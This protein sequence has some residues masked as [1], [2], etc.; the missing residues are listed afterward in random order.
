M[1]EGSGQGSGPPPPPAP[2]PPPPQP[3]DINQLAPRDLGGILGAAFDIY[4]MNAGGLVLIVAVV[5]IPLTVLSFLITHFA[6]AAK[7]HV[8]VIGNQTLNVIQP[9]SFAIVILAALVA[10]AISVIIT[11]VLQAAILRAAV[12][13]T[14]GEPVDVEASYRW[15]LR[16]FGSVLLVSILVGLAVA[17]GFILLIIP[18]IILLVLFS[19]SVSAVVVEHAHGTEAMRR[20]WN[21]TK[22]H[23]WHVLG[24]IVVAALIAG[25][26]TAVLSAIGG[27][28]AVL[29]L[30]LETIGQI[31][32]APFSALVTVILYLDL[33]ARSGSLTASG[34]RTELD[35]N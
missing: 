15:G 24:V 12:Q 30:I 1:D 23:F 25:A 31:I 22:G 18:G 17:I 14:I 7:T 32:V 8:V 16:R 29:R 28:S 26:V 6:L 10:A 3:G 13:A 35:A 21:L 33:R 5:V 34:L 19:V 11:A 20:S 4:R 2:P 9:R 27:S